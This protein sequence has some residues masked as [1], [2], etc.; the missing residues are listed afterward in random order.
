MGISFKLQCQVSERSE[1]TLI[2]CTLQEDHFKKYSWPLLEVNVKREYLLHLYICFMDHIYTIFIFSLLLFRFFPLK[3]YNNHEMSLLK[4][5]THSKISVFIVM[6][7]LCRLMCVQ[8]FCSLCFDEA[9]VE[10][11][12]ANHGHALYV[13]T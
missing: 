10:A 2:I 11:N 3:C 8:I 4:D 5:N 12:Q 13:L 9:R 6:S 1:N 7:S